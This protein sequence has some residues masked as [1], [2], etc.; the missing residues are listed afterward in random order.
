MDKYSNEWLVRPHQDVCLM[1][2]VIDVYAHQD[3]GHKIADELVRI[4]CPVNEIVTDIDADQMFDYGGDFR[5]YF[6]WEF[7]RKSFLSPE[8]VNTY[9]CVIAHNGPLPTYRGRDVLHH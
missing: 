1:K 5:F 8:V 6:G 7:G 3:L 9:F 4:G 2:K